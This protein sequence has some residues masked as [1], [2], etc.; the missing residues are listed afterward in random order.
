MTVATRPS[1]RAD[2][3]GLAAILVL[4][5]AAR[6]AGIGF[7]LPNTETRPDE[8]IAV[9]V[10]VHMAKNHLHPHFFEYPTLFPTVL[11][12]LYAIYFVAGYASGQFASTEAFGALYYTDPSS[13]YLIAR[14]VGAACGVVTVYLVYVVGKRL[15]GVSSGLL[16]ALFLALC[17]IHVRDSHF[18]KV[19]IPMTCLMVLTAILALEVHRRGRLR[20][21]LLAGAVAGLAASTKYSAGILCLN[22][23]FAHL[24]RREA[25]RA[26]K[27]VF[28]PFLWGAALAMAGAFIAGSPY[29]LIDWRGFW[30][31]LHRMTGYVSG[32]YGGHS[33]EGYGAG[34]G[35]HATFSLRYGLGL[36]ME[37]LAFAGVLRAAAR[38]RPEECIVLSFLAYVA[39]V[40]NG[41]WVFTRYII[42]LVPFLLIFS[43]AFLSWAG[44]LLKSHRLRPAAVWLAAFLVLAEPVRSVVQF[45]RLLLREDTRLLAAAWVRA[46][47]PDGAAIALHGG[48]YAEP[49]L[50]ESE[51]ML[52]ERL[53]EN[54]GPNRDT[55]LLEHPVH[56]RYRLIRLGYFDTADRVHRT[57]VETD[58]DGTTLARRSVQYVVTQEAPLRDFAAVEDRMRR[59]LEAHASREALFDPFSPG[60]LPI[61]DPLDAFFVPLAGFDG[62]DRPGPRIAIY[63]LNPSEK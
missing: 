35:Y 21:Y 40:G 44:G 32:A 52:R 14:L 50:S 2:A 17:P 16:A 11:L 54:P 6:V 59:F 51:D 4:A 15:Y 45:D 34:W 37:I 53:R 31:G 58:Y 23:L 55:Y 42:P 27:R 24:L 47:V 61:Y 38:R 39:L 56:P 63:R 41:R 8:S 62:V 36:A 46:H 19:D 25:V 57:W 30:G 48:Y 33:E 12:V 9:S 10:A 5:T 13:F 22:I 3:Y 28:H 20:D 18:G 1:G 60:S 43:A 7:G 29:V 26:W 49:Q